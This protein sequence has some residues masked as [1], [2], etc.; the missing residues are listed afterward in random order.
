[1]KE[2]PP[3]YDEQLVAWCRSLYGDGQRS[4]TG[5]ELALRTGKNRN[6]VSQLEKDGHASWEVLIL[7]A[8]AAGRPLLEGLVVAGYVAASE[9]GL[10]EF[11]VNDQERGLV[12]QY[13][14]L[15]IPGRDLALGAIQGMLRSEE[16]SSELR[17]AV[18]DPGNYQVAEESQ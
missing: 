13:R 15:P 4:A 3:N 14:K 1:M 6:T 5:Q 18:E 9:A 16:G 8:R 10:D 7:I 2:K 11:R 12:E 17:R